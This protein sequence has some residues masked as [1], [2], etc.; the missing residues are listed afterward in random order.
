MAQIIN[1]KAKAMSDDLV[2]RDEECAAEE[3][4]EIERCLKHLESEIY[5]LT[6][7][8]IIEVAIRNPSVM[9]YIKHWEGR[10]EKAEAEVSRLTLDHQRRKETLLSLIN[11]VRSDFKTAH[12]EIIKLQ[13][14]DPEKYTWPDW[15]PQANTLRWMDEI[16]AA[17]ISQPVEE[18]K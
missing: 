10:A 16:E 14:G 13:G 6:R 7:A 2:K 8:G 11:Q 3:L 12:A 9:E 17:L 1:Q 18:G 15:S 4:S 5:M